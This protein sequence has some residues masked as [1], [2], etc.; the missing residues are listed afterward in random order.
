MKGLSHDVVEWPYTLHAPTQRAIFGARTVPGLKVDGEKVSGSR[1]IMRRLEQLA[2]EPPLVPSDPEARARVEDAAQG[3]A[4]I[5]ARLTARATSKR[6]W[7][8]GCSGSSRRGPA[9]AH[10]A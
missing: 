5:G 4:A 10:R 7:G 3:R 6:S 9:Q 2:P 8:R 1:A